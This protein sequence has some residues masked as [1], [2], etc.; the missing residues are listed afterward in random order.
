MQK[1]LRSPLEDVARKKGDERIDHE[2]SAGWSK[3]LCD[4]T[5]AYRA[6]RGQ[7]DHAFHEIEHER[8]ESTA[9]SEQQADP[10]NATKRLA[11][12]TRAT[13]RE[14]SRARSCGVLNI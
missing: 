14:A 1:G 6:K 10:H 8:C 9:A 7:A 2:K 12:T 3:Q 5:G 13:C 11:P 4:A